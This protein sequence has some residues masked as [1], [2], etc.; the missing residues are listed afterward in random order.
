MNHEQKILAQAVIDRVLEYTEY[1][2]HMGAWV[3]NG[4][5]LIAFQPNDYELLKKIELI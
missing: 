3:T 5:L 2:E 1:D 4:S